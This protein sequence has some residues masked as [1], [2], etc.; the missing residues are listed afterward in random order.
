MHTQHDNART[1][2]MHSNSRT[3]TCTYTRNCCT[4]AQLMNTLHTTRMHTARQHI[5]FKFAHDVCAQTMLAQVLNFQNHSQHK[6]MQRDNTY[7]ASWLTKTHA[8]T[9]CWPKRSFVQGPSKTSSQH[10]CSQVNKRCLATEYAASGN[11]TKMS[12]GLEL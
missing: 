5:R 7:D 1:T 10:I 9:Q 6:C 12:R 11:N 2:H 3:R 4:R 8:H